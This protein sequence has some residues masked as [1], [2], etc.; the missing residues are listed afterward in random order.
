MSSWYH[1]GVAWIQPWAHIETGLYSR[2][3]AIQGRALIAR[4]RY[5]KGHNE[6][7][8]LLTEKIGGE[9]QHNQGV[10]QGVLGRPKKIQL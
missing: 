8:P 7:G 3:G 6:T 9:L 2:E 10:V 1:N 5:I 4:V